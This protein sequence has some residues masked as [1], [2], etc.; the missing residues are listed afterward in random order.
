MYNE[1]LGLAEVGTAV[2]GP[3]EEPPEIFCNIVLSYYRNS[4]L[5]I[6]LQSK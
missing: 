5:C 4:S 2:E 1:V 3:G 6:Y